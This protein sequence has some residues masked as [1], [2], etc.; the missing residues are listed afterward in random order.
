MKCM[1]WLKTR[2]VSNGLLVITLAGLVAVV[3]LFWLE[4]GT[5]NRL[6]G[7]AKAQDAIIKDY[8]KLVIPPAAPRFSGEAV[9]HEKP[10]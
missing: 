2:Q 1:K 10:W 5:C 7:I 9:R 6:I 4:V 3:G 8:E